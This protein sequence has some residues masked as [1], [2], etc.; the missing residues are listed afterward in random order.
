[1]ISIAKAL[2]AFLPG[3]GLSG[4]LHEVFEIAPPAEPWRR[5][6]EERDLAVL[7]GGLPVSLFDGE[8]TSEASPRSPFH[9]RGF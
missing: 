4:R 3:F 5:R 7:R 2:R 1:M 6:G 9:S 8:Q